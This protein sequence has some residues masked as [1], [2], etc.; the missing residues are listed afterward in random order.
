MKHHRCQMPS[1]AGRTVWVCPECHW[2]WRVN[3]VVKRWYRE[4]PD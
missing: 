3:P 1:A 2:T 4:A